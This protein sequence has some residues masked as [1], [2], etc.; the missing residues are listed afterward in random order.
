ML[1]KMYFDM[2][3]ILAGT[4]DHYS[5]KYL[6]EAASNPNNLEKDAKNF[7]NKIEN[8]LHDWKKNSSAR[9]LASP[10]AKLI[11]N[12]GGDFKQIRNGQVD[13]NIQ[14]V[15]NHFKSIENN[16]EI[17]KA[18]KIGNLKDTM[19]KIE[20]IH[21]KIIEF[22]PYYIKGF[23]LKIDLIRQEYEC[24]SLLLIMFVSSLLIN[25]NYF[26]HEFQK[27]NQKE[28]QEVKIPKLNDAL[29][30][31]GF[32]GKIFGNMFKFFKGIYVNWIQSR[33]INN[34]HKEIMKSTHKQYLEAIIKVY[35]NETVS[36]IKQE[37]V[38]YLNETYDDV[39]ATLAVIFDLPN[40]FYKLQLM[41]IDFWGIAKR[42]ISS[43]VPLL[44]ISNYY[45]QERKL[46]SID[47]LQEEVEFLE[48]NIKRLE[49]IN[50]L[51]EKKKQEVIQKQTI[52]LN[53]RKRRIAKIKA[54]FDII[55]SEVTKKVKESDAKIQS[56]PKPKDDDLVL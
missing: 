14:F 18:N 5:K 13:K 4:D 43:V 12:S 47:A 25:S 48:S 50:T 49:K 42:T 16:N 20:D 29:N 54:E 8:L 11:W 53:K 19:K 17:L 35:Q 6:T 24:F 32:L 36:E 34:I 40:L 21:S 27:L 3:E 10:D 33:T 28:K 46:N 15:I 39:K 51:P 45:A 22:T 7:M 23:D 41:L 37:S 44:R 38:E 52:E 9:E 55:D 31:K 2:Y 30:D 26:L 56:M 1:D